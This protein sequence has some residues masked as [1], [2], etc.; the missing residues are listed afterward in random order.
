MCR[1]KSYSLLTLLFPYK[2]FDIPERS[3]R[4]YKSSYICYRIGYFGCEFYNKKRKVVDETRF[5]TSLM[6]ILSV[7][8]VGLLSEGTPIMHPSVSHLSF[9]LFRPT[10][11][12]FIW[13]TR[14]NIRGG[15]YSYPLQFFH[16]GQNIHPLIG[17]NFSKFVR[18]LWLTLKLVR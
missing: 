4:I 3:S 2:I 16:M 1:H 8:Q 13:V 15:F 14:F 6:I 7:Y 5:V 18:V 10:R 17:Y 11:I 9:H 12:L